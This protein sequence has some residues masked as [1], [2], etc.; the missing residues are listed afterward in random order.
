MR[1]LKE[2]QDFRELL[3][4]YVIFIT[5]NDKIGNGLPVYH[6]ERVITETNETVGDGSHII[7]V[8]GDYK[9]DD[10]IGKLIHDFHCK[11]SKD[12]YYPELAQGVKNFKE[13]EGG[14]DDM[15]NTLEEFEVEIAQKAEVKNSENIAIKMLKAGKYALDEIA[16]LTDLTTEQVKMLQK[17]I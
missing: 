8:N 9:G 6:L 15:C 1:K 16:N 12:I 5:E 17:R 10:P 14:R 3:G 7:Y 4:S 2:K 13:S 11:E